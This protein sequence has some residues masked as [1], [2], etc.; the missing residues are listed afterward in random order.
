MSDS[1][2]EHVTNTIFPHLPKVIMEVDLYTVQTRARAVHIYNVLSGII[3][4][5]SD[6]F[7]VSKA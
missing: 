1:Q 7:P 2:V 5:I 6:S 4:T 3:F